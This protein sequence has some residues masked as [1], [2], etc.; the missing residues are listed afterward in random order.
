MTGPN[1]QY[2]AD[3][4]LQDRPVKMGYNFIIAFSGRKKMPEQAEG[5]PEEAREDACFCRI[6]GAKLHFQRLYLQPAHTQKPP[7][8][9]KDLREEPSPIPEQGYQLLIFWSFPL[10]PFFSRRG[11]EG[12][13]ERDGYGKAGM[14]KGELQAPPGPCP[15]QGNEAKK[16]VGLDGQIT[17]TL[18]VVIAESD[19]HR[20]QEEKDESPYNQHQQPRQQHLLLPSFCIYSLF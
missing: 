20:Q 10:P 14:K 1:L 11:L 18:P 16:Q 17:G 6:T 12:A 3:P 9:G 7:A 13:G 2:T 5:A 19:G 8:V 4:D 15:G